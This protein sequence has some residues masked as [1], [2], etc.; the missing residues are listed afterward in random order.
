M[1]LRRLRIGTRL[2]IGFGIVLAIL[3]AMVGL[4]NMLTIRNKEALI[5]GLN[6]AKN[7][8]ALATAMKNGLFEG[9]I[10]IRNIGLQSDVAAMRQEIAYQKA[11]QAAYAAARDKLTALG[12]TAPEKEIIANL[13]KIDKQL[14]APMQEAIAGAVE[15]AM[16][17]DSGSVSKIF[18]QQINPLSQK[19]LHEINT[20]VDIQV[21]A[22]NAFLE[23]S[24]AGD[25]EMVIFLTML[26]G[27]GLAIGAFCA[28][29]ITR[30]ITQPLRQAVVVAQGVATGDLTYAIDDRNTD[31]IGQLFDA[32]RQMNASLVDIVGNVRQGTESIGVASGEIADGNADLSART[33]IQA[34]A[35]EETASSMGELTATVRNNADNA[36][37]ANL[38][39]IAATKVAGKGGAVVSQVVGTMG[40]IK[41]SSRKIADIIGVIDGIAFQTNILALNAAV[42]AARAGEQGRGFAVVASEVRNLAQRSAAAAREIKSL[43]DDSVQKVD[44]GNQL[45]DTAGHTMSEIVS[46]IGRVTIIMAE[47]TQASRK[48][49]GG[50]EEV[51]RVIAEIDEMTQKNA[52]LV[53]QAAAAAMSMQEQAERLVQTV[54]V[55]KLA[56]DAAAV[57]LPVQTAHTPLLAFGLGGIAKPAES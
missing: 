39:A 7:K 41:E 17:F 6:S 24:I 53:V 54:S 3:V 57:P 55:F 18:A 27:F 48:Q 37:A 25:R 43:I 33:E 52:E 22:S 11:Q 46:S 32:L 35:L 38:L 19:A 49:S 31:E 16:A 28:W 8:E 14:E 9:G 4:S 42:E 15:Q 45:V 13:A 21:K 30:S 23:S 1:G 26:G 36:H 20:L 44:A 5:S 12:L 56:G 50:I 47:I 29:I 34:A 40:A 10:A 51:N 2:K